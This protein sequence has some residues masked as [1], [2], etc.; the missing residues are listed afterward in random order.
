M[1]SIKANFPKVLLSK[2]GK[3]LTYSE[4][5][6][7]NTTEEFIYIERKIPVRLTFECH[8]AIDRI[9]EDNGYSKDL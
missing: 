9:L 6:E 7:Q 1:R 5:E 4:F 2:D 3:E 8:E